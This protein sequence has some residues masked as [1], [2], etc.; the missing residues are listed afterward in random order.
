MQVIV[1]NDLDKEFKLTKRIGYRTNIDYISK[2][3]K[4]KAFY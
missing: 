4:Q 1:K 3:S 2:V